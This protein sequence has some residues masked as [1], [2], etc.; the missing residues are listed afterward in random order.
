M[1][2]LATTVLFLCTDEAD[3][4]RASLPAVR[5]QPG[6]EI[7]VVDNASTDDT[8]EIARN[9]GVE[10][11]RLERRHTYC[12][13][14]NVALAKTGGDA[15]LL[16][17]P[18]C[19]LTPG[20]LAA[21]RPRLEEDR[22]GAV[23]PKLLRTLGP[24][25]SRR[26]SVID[27]VGIFMH[28]CRKNLLQGHDR[29]LPVYDVPAEVFGADGAA[30]LY[31]REMLEDCAEGGAIFDE[32]FEQW[33]SDV[34]LAWRARLLGWRCVYEPAAVAYHVRGY[35]PATRNAMPVR[36]RRL[37]LQNRYLMMAKNDTVRDLL[38]DLHLI[39]LYEALALGY[40]L[41][42]DWKVLGAYVDALRLLGR[43]RRK[44]V[45]IQARRRERGTGR[46]PFGARLPRR[47]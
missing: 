23:A 39:A 3:D 6:A 18:D 11:L 24:E 32:D 25:P 8:G 21:A 41:L 7:V 2:D 13:A 1:R 19:F 17:N 28:R 33:A 5:V 35:R 30:A 37:V 38:P 34:D 10:Y 44:G 16:L 15:V 31:R 27:S 22:V 43:A 12:Q 26:L 42:R 47:A 9:H 20:F 40:V 29:A 14:L 4:L 36:A 46:L 45:A